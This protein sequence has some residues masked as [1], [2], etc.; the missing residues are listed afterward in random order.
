MPIMFIPMKIQKIFCGITAAIA[1]QLPAFSADAEHD[2]VDGRWIDSASQRV[3][4]PY[5]HGSWDIYITGYAWHAGP[6]FNGKKLNDKTYGGGFGRRWVDANGHEDLLYVIGFPDSYH[7][8][9]PA[10]GYMRQW[11]TKSIGPL[12]LGGGFTAAVTARADILHYSPLPV[13][14]P[15]GSIR[16]NKLSLMGTMLPRKKGALG[17]IWVRYQF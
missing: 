10:A 14:L 5:R 1:L 15:V 13:L 6:L 3:I 12:S 16:F 8:F 17:I 2:H 11:F 4:N 7:H 9:Q